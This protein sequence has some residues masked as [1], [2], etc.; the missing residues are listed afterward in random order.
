MFKQ[1][2]IYHYVLLLLLL[3]LGLM[4]ASFMLIKEHSNYGFER[5]YIEMK[6]TK[7]SA[8]ADGNTFKGSNV[9][10]IDNE[11]EKGFDCVI[12]HLEQYPY[13]VLTI[14]IRDIKMNGMDFSEFTEMTVVGSFET[15]DNDFLRVGFRHFDAG[16]SLM[17]SSNSMKFNQMELKSEEVKRNFVIEFDRLTVPSWWVA[18]MKKDNVDD[19]VELNHI[20]YIEFSTGTL[21]SE[22]EYKLRL[23]YFVFEKEVMNISKVYE[24]LLI[25]WA[26][27][28]MLIMSVIVFVLILRL[29]AKGNNEK[30]LIEINNALSVKSVELELISQ[31]D[32]LTGAFNRFGLQKKLINTVKNKQYPSI[33]TLVDIDHFKSINDTFGHQKGDYVL[34]KICEIIKS[35]L[36]NDESLSR[37]GG[38]EFLILMPNLSVS[39]V[40]DRIEEIRVGIQISD[41]N[42]NREVTA[43]FGVAQLNKNGNIKKIINEADK[44]LYI[45]KSSGRNCISY[46]D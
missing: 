5:I 14:D 4:V 16:Y 10:T 38:E 20:S 24:Y 2:R 13:C 19:L 12:K 44:A 7:F 11:F 31:T 36:R 25:F 18:G 42:I 37:Y 17:N 15:P 1:I 32:A 26:V 22:G 41:M 28:L 3:I 29:K 23:E 35:H 30:I 6:D 43:S 39:Q 45:A 9:K 8:Y 46:G 33:V 27:F 40:K 21:P 34:E